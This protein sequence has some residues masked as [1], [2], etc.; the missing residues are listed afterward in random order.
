VAQAIY[1]YEGADR[2]GGQGAGDEV[3]HRRP[4]MC[5]RCLCK[6]ACGGTEDAGRGGGPVAPVEVAH[7]FALHGGGEVNGLR[8]WT[9]RLMGYSRAFW[10]SPRARRP[11]CGCVGSMEGLRSTKGWQGAA[12][13]GVAGRCRTPR[14]TRAKG[15]VPSRCAETR[16]DVVCRE[17]RGAGTGRKLMARGGSKGREADAAERSSEKT[18]GW[19]RR[20]RGRRR[21]KRVRGRC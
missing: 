9:S 6:R 14:S 16:R 4:V 18:R 19:S 20:L 2:G 7:R 15:R 13:A 21:V 17:V 1:I 8:G 3:E 11:G 5:A 12:M 10:D